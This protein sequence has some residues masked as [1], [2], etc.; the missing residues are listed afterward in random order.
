[1]AQTAKNG[2]PSEDQEQSWLVAWFRKEYPA[3]RMFAIPN[4]GHRSKADGMLLK[5]TGVVAGVPDLM[6]AAPR[7]AWHGLFV[8]MKVQ[9]GGRVSTEQK[10]WIAY[11]AEQ[12][13]RAEVCNG[14]EA[15]KAVIREY[16]NS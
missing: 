13:Y 12:G 7:G 2:L 9:S 8:E 6:V 14:F 10:E 4:G 16:M 11:L 15:A 3:V 1:M 5:A